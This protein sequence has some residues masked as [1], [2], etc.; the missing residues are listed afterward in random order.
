MRV[1][2]LGSGAF[3]Q[4]YQA[5][6]SFLATTSTDS[7]F[8]LKAE[9][10]RY[11]DD[12]EKLW[13]EA[14]R[15]LS[16][17][18]A[19]L[20]D[21]QPE[22]PTRRWVHSL[23]PHDAGPATVLPTRLKRDSRLDGPAEV[24]R[25]AD[26]VETFVCETILVSERAPRLNRFALPRL[27]VLYRLLSATR[28]HV[29]AN[30]A[31]RFVSDFDVCATLANAGFPSEQW[32]TF[33]T[34]ERELLGREQRT[35]QRGSRDGTDPR[36]VKATALLERVNVT[37]LRHGLNGAQSSGVVR[38]MWDDIRRWRA[39]SS[40]NKGLAQEQE[41]VTFVTSDSVSDGG[42]TGQ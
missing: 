12:S 21:A 22:A 11:P 38:Q 5:V 35:V 10:E 31:P 4:R 3:R 16:T 6:W 2:K 32:E 42:L 1:G 34:W 13:N 26:Q 41:R 15:R 28:A 23:D 39:S 9:I 17:E 27:T 19:R 25:L 14:D 36:A 24:T 18:L 8:Q 7:L 20:W 33:L 37:G 30:L 29:H 40:G